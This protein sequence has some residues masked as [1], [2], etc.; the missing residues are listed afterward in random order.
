M[1]RRGGFRCYPADPKRSPIVKE[2]G[3]KVYKLG[4]SNEIESIRRGFSTGKLNQLKARFNL[5][6][7]L[8]IRVV[9]L[10]KSTLG[11][12]RKTE[13]PLDAIA[14]DRLYRLDKILALA[15]E[16]FQDEREGLRWLCRAQ[17][18]LGGSVPMEV[19]DTQ[20]GAEAV[21]DLLS[22]LEH[23]VYP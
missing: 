4:V 20:P 12:L 13:K 23:A 7:D 9:G 19:L 22:Q 8:L 6:D 14:S 16:V 5:T 17:P 18:G 3:L 10:S 11:R 2:K 15:S 1:G 21:K